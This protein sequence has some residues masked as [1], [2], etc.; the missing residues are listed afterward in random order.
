MKT[1]KSAFGQHHASSAWRV[2]YFSL[3]HGKKAK[4]VATGE[5]S[6]EVKRSFF[7]ELVDGQHADWGK[8]FCAMSSVKLVEQQI[9][10]T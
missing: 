9:E 7:R 3:A 1:K 5:K 10:Q 4:E 2:E 8:Q 6:S